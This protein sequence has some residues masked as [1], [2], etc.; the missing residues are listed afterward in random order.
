[1]RQRKIKVVLGR[2]RRRERER[3]VYREER[4]VGGGKCR[5]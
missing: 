1:V 4:R 3:E 2:E 5:E